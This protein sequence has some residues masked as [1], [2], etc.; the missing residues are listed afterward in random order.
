MSAALFAVPYVVVGNVIVLNRNAAG[1]WNYGA[2]IALVTDALVGDRLPVALHQDGEQ[3]RDARGAGTRAGP[4]Q[5]LR[6]LDEDGS[7]R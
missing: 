6:Q 7:A 5:E 3:A 4:L 1:S 2:G